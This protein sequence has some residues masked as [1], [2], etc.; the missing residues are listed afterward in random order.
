MTERDLLVTFH[1]RSKLPAREFVTHAKLMLHGQ[2]YPSVNV[3]AELVPP[4]KTSKGG[5]K[6]GKGSKG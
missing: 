1:L 2:E 6:N 3:W 5:K 4:L